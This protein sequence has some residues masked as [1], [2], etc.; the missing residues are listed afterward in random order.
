MKRDGHCLCGAT[1]YTV[2][3]AAK[4]A[5]HCYCSDCQRVT[6]GAAAAQVAFAKDTVT[7]RG[8]LKHHFAT[9]DSGNT[10]DFGFCGECGSPVVKSTTRAPDLMFVYLGT[11]NDTDGL[12]ALKP[13]FEE[14]RPSWDMA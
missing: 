3:G 4:F 13:L 5:I 1:S 8:P 10:L 2:T 11:L 6:G 14:S 12:P 7:V 9:A